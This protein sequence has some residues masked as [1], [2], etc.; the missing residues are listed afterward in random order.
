MCKKLHV[1]YVYVLTVISHLIEVIPVKTSC[2]YICRFVGQNRIRIVLG[3]IRYGITPYNTGGGEA[4][5]R[6][7][8]SVSEINRFIRRIYAVYMP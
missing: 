8:L 2:M 6:T 1:P 3:I 7:V 5:L 4:Y